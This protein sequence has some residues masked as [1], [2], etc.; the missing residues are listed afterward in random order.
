MRRSDEN[1]RQE[2]LDPDGQAE[3]GAGLNV[4]NCAIRAVRN[5]RLA[6]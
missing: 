1:E 2:V 3:V 6:A 5:A 4:R